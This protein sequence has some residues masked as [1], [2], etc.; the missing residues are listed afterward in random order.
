MVLYGS[1]GYTGSLIAERAKEKGQKLLLAGRNKEKLKAQS[2]Q[3]GFPYRVVSL[4]QPSVL[5]RLLK[6]EELVIHA[7]GPFQKTARAMMEACIDSDTH[8]LDITGEIQVFELSRKLQ[9]EAVK[10]GV[11]LMPGVGFDVVPTDCLAL[12]LKQQLPDANKLEIAFT[13]AHG[14]MSRGTRR[15]TIE[16]M[17]KPGA[18]RRNGKIVKVPVAKHVLTVPF[19]D[20]PRKCMSI[21]W[22]DVSTAYYSTGIPN[23][24]TYTAASPKTIRKAKLQPYLRWLLNT[25]AAKKRML[26]DLES[27]PAGPSPEQREQAYSMVWARVSNQKGETRSARWKGPEG[28][29]LTA[30]TALAI[31]RAVMDGNYQ[32]GPHTPAEL[33]GPDFILDFPGSERESLNS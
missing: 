2:E 28:Y 8:Y 31:A 10:A 15:T 17:G 25:A 12:H 23:I 33:Y 1:Y 6:P 16:G 4:D 13:T 5:R 26:K 29:T 32:V 9:A 3:T 24:I 14:K 18:E 27:R 11:L 22:G 21:P 30:M 7:A 20:K 19:Q